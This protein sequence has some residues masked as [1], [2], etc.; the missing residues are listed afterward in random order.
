MRVL[1]LALLLATAAIA[2]A[3]PAQIILI[4]H[5]EKPADP[6]AVHLSKEGQQ[7]ARELVHFVTSTPELKQHGLPAALFAT[8]TTKHGR[9]QRTQETLAPLAKEL[10]LPIQTPFGSEE[11]KEMARAVLS[12]HKLRGKT[13]LIC[14]T[15]EF[16]PELAAALGVHPQPPKWKDENYDRVYLISYEKGGVKLQE[17]TQ[18][19]SPGA[20]ES[21]K[22]KH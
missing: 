8:R 4:R 14:W 12:N 11:Y 13:I 19:F 15:H 9:G 18:P 6:E 22:Q 3:Q 7:R 10:A 16:I 17:L 2:R 21:K 20:S 1:T 5:A